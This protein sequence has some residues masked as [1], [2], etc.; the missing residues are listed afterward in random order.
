MK[1]FFIGFIS[2]IFSEQVLSEIIREDDGIIKV[3]GIHTDQ[4]VIDSSNTT[5]LCEVG[6]RIVTSNTAIT[7]PIFTASGLENIRIQ[8]CDIEI[9]NPSKNAIE[10]INYQQYNNFR[11]I[12]L[13]D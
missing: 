7:V 13:R 5:L 10:P 6:S 4:I 1:L 9:N 11:S 12:S 3:R 2:I 8:N